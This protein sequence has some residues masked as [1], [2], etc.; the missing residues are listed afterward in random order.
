M[1]HPSFSNI[2]IAAQAIIKGAKRLIEHQYPLIIVVEK[3]IGKVLGQTINRLQNNTS[4]KVVCIDGIRVQNG[5]YIDIGSPLAGGSVVP[6]V[7]KT[8]IFQ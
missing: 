4:S 5:D 3:D 8:L 7:I 6:V 1:E 2:E